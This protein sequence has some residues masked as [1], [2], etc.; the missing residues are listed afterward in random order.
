M[1]KAGILMGSDSDLPAL[2]PLFKRLKEFGIPYE[3]H[4]MSAHRTPARACEFAS[5]ARKNGFGV[6][7]AA[8]GKAAHL[9]GVV[10]AHTTLPVIGIP[11]KNSLDGLDALLS[12]VQMPAGIPVATV[13]IDG[14]DNAGILAAQ[15]LSLAD[16]SIAEK[17]EKFKVDMTEQ[18]MAKDKKL[19]EKLQSI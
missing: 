4:V 8:A 13:A 9:A 18:V 17:L 19:Q 16:A 3:A 15:I 11:V 5:N 10:A 1:K 2:E 6:V 12:T 7:I 14:A